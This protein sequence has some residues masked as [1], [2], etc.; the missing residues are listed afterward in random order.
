[1]QWNGNPGKQIHLPSNTERNAWYVSAI[2]L[3]SFGNLHRNSWKYWQSPMCAQQILRAQRLKHN[4]HSYMYCWQCVCEVTTP[5]SFWQYPLHQAVQWLT[6]SRI[7]AREIH[8]GFM[9]YKV[10][11]GQDSVFP[12]QYHS[13]VVLHTHISSGR[14]IS[15]LVAA[16]Q[17]HSFTPRSKSILFTMVFSGWWGGIDWQMVTYDRR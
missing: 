3:E 14:W 9:V 8:V 1:M 16:V 10:A 6:R 11:L 17:R 5:L 15:P 12:C 13:T 7:R 4:W 2:R